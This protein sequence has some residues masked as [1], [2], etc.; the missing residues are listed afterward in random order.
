[1]LDPNF[2]QTVVLMLAHDKNGA[3]GVVVNRPAQA[4]GVPFPIFAGGPCPSQGLL[5][6]HGHP[7]WLE[8]AED[9]EE[10]KA[11]CPGVYLGNPDCATRVAEADESDQYRYRM[12]LGY[13]GWGPGQLEGELA[14]GAW[15]IS[16]ASDE[17]M[18]DTP[19]EELWDRLA[20]PRI[21]EFSLN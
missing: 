10:S 13:A 4:E 7:E 3:F 1:L 2:R 18:F 14:S 15:M 9:E 6:L 20:P 16:P 19:P 17:L 5:M 8:P 11:I 12:F 21:P